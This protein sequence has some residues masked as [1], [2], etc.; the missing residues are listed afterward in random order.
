MAAVEPGRSVYVD[1]LQNL[2]C[3]SR[4]PRVAHFKCGSCCLVPCIILFASCFFLLWLCHISEEV[5]SYLLHPLGVRNFVAEGRRLLELSGSPERSRERAPR[6]CDL[7]FNTA[8]S[9]S[10]WIF[11]RKE[12]S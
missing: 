1:L 6:A 9:M 2:E 3:E 5:C 10:R 8:S 7:A 11:E 4:S 12:N